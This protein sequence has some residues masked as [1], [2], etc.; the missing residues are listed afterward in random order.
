MY[1]DHSLR[2]CG[3]ETMDCSKSPV[4]SAPGP[5]YRERTAY[6]QGGECYGGPKESN[7]LIPKKHKRTSCW[8]HPGKFSCDSKTLTKKASSPIPRCFWV[9]CVDCQN[10][11][12]QSPPP[13][14]IHSQTLPRSDWSRDFRR[15]RQSQRDDVR[16]TGKDRQ[17]Q[18]DRDKILSLGST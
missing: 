3:R 10:G 16:E 14:P 7:Q 13:F 1:T 15:T 5:S 4:P 8:G 12:E 11:S 6:G 2:M 18:T 17:R 9:R